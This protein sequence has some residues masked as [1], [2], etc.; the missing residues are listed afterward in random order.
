M[1]S[2]FLSRCRFSAWGGRVPY[3]CACVLCMV[4]G[5]G[6]DG[7]PYPSASPSLGGGSEPKNPSRWLGGVTPVG[8]ACCGVA[9][10]R[11][12]CCVVLFPSG[13]RPPFQ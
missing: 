4:W 12:G 11:R 1:A 6:V 7:I 2:P 9:V 3:V 10:G 13:K 8:V 5:Y